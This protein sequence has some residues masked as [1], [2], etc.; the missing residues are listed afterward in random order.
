MARRGVEVAGAVAVEGV[1]VAV[2][3]EGVEGIECFV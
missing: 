1:E 2:A 3:G